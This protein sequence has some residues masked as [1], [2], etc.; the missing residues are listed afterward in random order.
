MYKKNKIGLFILVIVCSSGFVFASQTVL[1]VPTPSCSFASYL[2]VGGGKAV[3]KDEKSPLVELSYGF[4]ISPWISLGAFIAANPLSN[5][6]HANLGVAIAQTEAAFALM[7][8]T[9]LVFTPSSDNLIHPIIRLAIGGVSVGYL[10][11]IDD[12]EGYDIATTNRYTFASFSAGLELNI[13]T[14]LRLALRGGWRFA[15]N[16]KTMG[17]EKYGLS[18]LEVSLSLRTVWQTRIN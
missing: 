11:D 12:E 5:F 6:V 16:E 1:D 17:I 2:N 13:M 8:G 9:E 14:H 15:A 4:Q 18:G 3:I 7:S 10:E